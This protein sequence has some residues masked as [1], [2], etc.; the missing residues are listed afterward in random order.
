MHHLSVLGCPIFDPYPNILWK[1]CSKPPTS[2]AIASPSIPS[3][4]SHLAA[5][6]PPEA[7][8]GSPC[9]VKVLPLPVWP[10]LGRDGGT[11]GVSEE[12]P[13]ENGRKMGKKGKMGERWEKLGKNMDETWIKHSFVLMNSDGNWT[14]RPMKSGIFPFFCVGNA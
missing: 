4:P 14:L 9:M 5:P 2:C 13:K 8:P 11:G 6:R 7:T 3:I 12:K 1:K 10:Y